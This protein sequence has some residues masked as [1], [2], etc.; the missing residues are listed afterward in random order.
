MKKVFHVVLEVVS[1][2]AIFLSPF[3]LFGAIASFVYFSDEKNS[4]LSITFLSVGSFLGI[5]WAER[6][7]NRYGCTEYMGRILATPDL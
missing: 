1:W 6:I 4:W 7:R 3:L 5:F 2:I